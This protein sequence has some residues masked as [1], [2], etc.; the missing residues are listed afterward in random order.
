MAPG[1]LLHELHLSIAMSNKSNFHLFKGLENNAIS[2]E[3]L[4][5][6]TKARGWAKIHLELR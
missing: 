2:L 3:N 5:P 4:R 1:K 6:E